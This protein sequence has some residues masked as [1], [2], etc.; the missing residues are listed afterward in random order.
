M[1]E[2]K[3]FSKENPDG[4]F[5]SCYWV[6]DGEKIWYVEKNHFRLCLDKNWKESL[7]HWMPI[8]K[9]ELPK[10]ELHYCKKNGFICEE[11]EGRLYLTFLHERC[12]M[13]YFSLINNCPFCGYSPKDPS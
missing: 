5:S 2:W 10:K 4:H 7:T 12:G 8:E 6:T 1:S 3:E 9:P 13:N 11:K